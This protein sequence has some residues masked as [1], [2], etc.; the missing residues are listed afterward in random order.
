M[1]SSQSMLL[2]TAVLA[3]PGNLLEVKISGPNPRNSGVESQKFFKFK[4]NF[5]LCI[6]FYLWLCLVFI[7]AQAFSLVAMRMATLVTVL[8]L[9]IAVAS[10]VAVTGSRHAGFLRCSTWTQKPW[11]TS[12]SAQA[13]WSWRTSIAAPWHMGCFPA[14][15]QTHVS[16]IG[17]RTM[18]H[19]ATKLVF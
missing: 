14:R 4:N 1:N 11:L 15:D 12:S 5:Y 13:Q 19:W 9:L 18:Y 7:A 8:W 6:Y 3:S 16:C 10:L 2:A 17:R